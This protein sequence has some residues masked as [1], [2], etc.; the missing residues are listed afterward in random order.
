MALWA[1]F[2]RLG[3]ETTVEHW[4]PEIQIW[5]NHDD[6]AVLCGIGVEQAQQIEICPLFTQ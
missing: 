1:N 6:G 2:S 3:A 4:I 5:F